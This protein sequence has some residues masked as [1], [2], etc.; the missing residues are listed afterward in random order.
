MSNKL[1][2]GRI[3]KLIASLNLKLYIALIVLFINAIISVAIAG[4]LYLK[5]AEAVKANPIHKG[6]IIVTDQGQI[7]IVFNKNAPVASQNFIKLTESG[8]YNGLRV[9]RI[10]PNVMIE[11]GDPLTRSD[12]LK[13]KWGNGG[14]G[15]TFAD[16][17]FAPDKMEKGVVA[18]VN[19]GPD[20]NGS[21]FFILATDAEWLNGQHT[22]L[23]WVAH[24]QSLVDQIASESV[25]VL[26]IP[27]Q[28]IY[29]KEII[30][31]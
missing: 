2:V 29:I 24:G 4:N 10:V 18:M 22:I 5:R 3:R 8:F 26:G 20:T 11:M 30:L 12:E 15:F 21:Q 9:H 23:G 31:K 19:N 28:D 14:P 13:S 7:E 1:N 27:L 6:A 17:I 16:E 25:S